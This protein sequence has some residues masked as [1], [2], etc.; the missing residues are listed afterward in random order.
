MSTAEP[1][2]ILGDAAPPVVAVVVTR[3]PGPFLEQSLAALGAQD[4]PALS[5]LVV[6]AGSQTRPDRAGRAPRC[7]TA[8]VRRSRGA[9][10]SAAPANEALA[11]VQGATFFLVCHDDVV[12]D[13]TR[14][15]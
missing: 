8:F 1:T 10:A 14:C 5:V 11:A 2:P 3:N 13:P 9:P 12:L 6:D 15:A 7:P 4:Y